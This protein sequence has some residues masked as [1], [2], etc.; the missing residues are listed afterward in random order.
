MEGQ[1]TDT[2]LIKENVKRNA[3]RSTITVLLSAAMSL[4]VFSAIMISQSL[5]KG[6]SSL[7]ER[8]G[9]DLLVVPKGYDESARAVLLTGAPTYFYMD[10]SFE[11]IIKKIPGV[12][13]TSAQFFL[14]S[15]S[16]GCCDFPVQIIGFDEKTDFVIKPWI[17]KSYS[18]H[19][20]RGQIFCGRNINISGGS[21]KFFGVTH[22]VASVL[23]K[24]SSGLDN[25]VFASF[26]TLQDIVSDAQKKGF[27]FI[28]DRD[29]QKS[30]STILVKLKDGAKKDSVAIKIQ[31]AIDGVQVIKKDSI[32]EK[33]AQGYS[34][35]ISFVYAFA[36]IACLSSFAALFLFYA[37][38]VKERQK[39]ISVYRMLGTSDFKI[40]N[41]L[42]GEVLTLSL[43]GAVSGIALSAVIIFNFSSVLQQK[44]SLPYIAPSFAKTFVT[45]ILTL[46]FTLIAGILSSVFSV[47]KIIRGTLYS[48]IREGER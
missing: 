33:I 38:E 20:E 9:C 24:S 12:E 7:N 1:I 16:E 5:K 11:E 32:L 35:I 46:F 23:S 22:S 26:E 47:E 30:V 25:A 6:A 17:S 28:G 34:G 36:F 27:A 3:L 48:Q 39:E 31:G 40:R 41:I 8:F 42:L 29:I 14:T 18:K 13:K 19:L 45:A 4:V 44:F 21:V 10:K 43:L 15:T 37:F 2:Y